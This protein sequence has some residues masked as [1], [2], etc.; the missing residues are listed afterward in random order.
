M[1]VC[2]YKRAKQNAELFYLYLGPVCYTKS[3]H[4]HTTEIDIPLIYQK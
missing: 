3:F 1:F 4:I 2:R